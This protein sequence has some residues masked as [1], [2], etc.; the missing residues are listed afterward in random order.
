MND[1]CALGKAVGVQ[2][3]A[4]TEPR[5]HGDDEVGLVDG[6][7]GGVAAVHTQQA[8]IVRLAVAENARSHQG[9]GGGHTGLFQQVAQ[10]LA[11]RRTAHTAAEVD[12][13]ALRLVDEAGSFLDVLFII[14]GH[15]ADEFRRFGGEL[16]GRRRDI[17]RD[18]DEHRAFA[19]GLCNAEGRTHRVGQILYPAHR[20]VVL[21]DGHRDT[22][23]VGLLEGVLTQQ[24]RGDIAGEGDHRHAVHVGRGNAGAKV[25]RT[26][27]AGG[28]HNAGTARGAGVTVRCVGRALLVGGQYVA[29]T[30]GVFIQ[31][32]IQIQHCAAR[33]AEQGIDALLDQHFDEDL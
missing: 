3:H 10:G 5:A 25:R 16:A 18:I 14:I 23:D 7:V 26:R 15:G 20:V 29:Y 2:R 31:L 9:V 1:F 33:I 17:L 12:D 28:Q 24:R 19:A 8:Q 11:A 32:V 4:V 22:L 27:A 13:G 30:I 6:L 21:G